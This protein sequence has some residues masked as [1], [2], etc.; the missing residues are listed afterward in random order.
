MT[1]DNI[2]LT[3]TFNVIVSMIAHGAVVIHVINNIV[4]VVGVVVV[5]LLLK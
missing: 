5:V 1:Q 2:L 4:A 3:I